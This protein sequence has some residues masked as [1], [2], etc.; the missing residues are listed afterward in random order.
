VGL[1]FW[2][3]LPSMGV[4]DFC[5]EILYIYS[6]KRLYLLVPVQKYR[7]IQPVIEGIDRRDADAEDVIY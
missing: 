5:K 6:E 1:G 4:W 2:K 7:E 3:N